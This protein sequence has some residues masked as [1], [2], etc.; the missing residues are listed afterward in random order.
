MKIK[1]AEMTTLENYLKEHNIPCLLYMGHT[2]VK[3]A[4]AIL[5]KGHYQVKMGYIS[6]IPERMM[7][8]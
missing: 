1:G 6:Q 4:V 5:I 7:Q 3:I 8:E 2:L